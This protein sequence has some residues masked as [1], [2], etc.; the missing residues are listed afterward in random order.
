MVNYFIDT[1]VRDQTKY[2]GESMIRLPS[3]RREQVSP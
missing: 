3:E 1:C 2:L